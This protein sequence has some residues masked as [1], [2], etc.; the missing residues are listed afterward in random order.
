M[1]E[2]VLIQAIGINRRSQLNI[3]QVKL[4]RDTHKIIGVE[5][6]LL[7]QDSPPFAFSPLQAGS[8]LIERNNLMG[9]L[10]LKANGRPDIFYAKEIF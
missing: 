1:K 4:P 5:T 6:G 3:F 2:Q 10:Q 9:V 8:G 7:I